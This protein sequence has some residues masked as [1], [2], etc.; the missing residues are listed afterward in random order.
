MYKKLFFLTTLAGLLLFGCADFDC[1]IPTTLVTVT[2]DADN[3]SP[4]LTQWVER[5]AKATQ[6]DDPT[7]IVVGLYEGANYLRNFEGWFEAGAITPFDFNTPITADL[8]LTAKWTGTN[9]IDVSAAAGANIVE[10]AIAYSCTNAAPGKAFTLIIDDNYSVGAQ[11][12]STANFNLTLMGYGVERTLQYSGSASNPLFYLSSSTASLTLA[13]N[14]TLNGINN[15]SVQLVYVQY[16]ATLTMEAGSKITEHT[17]SIDRAAV[18]ISSFEPTT[19]SRFIMNGGEVSGNKNIS[20]YPWASGGVYISNDAAFTMN[21]GTITGNTFGIAGGGAAERP[22]DI[23]VTLLFRSFILSNDAT[24][25]TIKL[26]ADNTPNAFII[27][28]SY[29]PPFKPVIDLIGAS[30]SDLLTRVKGYWAGKTVLQSTG[31]LTADNVAKFELGIFIG[32]NNT[33]IEPIG[34]S[35]KIEE[36]GPNVGKLV[37]K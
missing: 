1:C 17:T 9:S 8:T 25:G 30:T 33:E 20:N 36:S 12:I 13:N 7:K 34:Y 35:Y 6:P 37:V 16:G 27:D 2:Y 22:A 18:H 21:G 32:N 5:G 23:T 15:S 19:P 11:S 26:I 29:N 14:I 10:K 24:I 28:D 4:E 31:V 3:D